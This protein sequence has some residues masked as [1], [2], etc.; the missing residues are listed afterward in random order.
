[1]PNLKRL[2]KNMSRR[3]EP[4]RAFVRALKADL[5]GKK[6]RNALFFAF[7]TAGAL[8]VI[9]LALGSASCVY[10]YR[11]PN[12]LPDHP[13][14]AV[15][16]AV[17]SAELSLVYMNPERAAEVA[18]KHFEK[19]VEEIGAMAD[20]GKQV[21]NEDVERVTRAAEAA[22]ESASSPSEAERLDE[23][24]RAA[25]LSGAG[26]LQRAAEASEYLKPAIRNGVKELGRMVR[27]MPVQRRETYQNI[28]LRYEAEVFGMK[29]K[30]EQGNV[31]VEDEDVDKII[32]RV[33]PNQ[34]I[35]AIVMENVE[36]AEKGTEDVSPPAVN[37]PPAFPFSTRPQIRATS[38]V[39]VFQP[40]IVQEIMPVR[41]IQNRET[42]QN[43]ATGTL[44]AFGGGFQSPDRDAMRRYLQGYFMRLREQ[45]R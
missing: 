27:R 3:A 25:E 43:N 20:G 6:P 4:D 38:S 13:L 16:R 32:E 14:Y 44:G 19:R 9:A 45:Q 37:V 2:L 11:S 10:A 7:R 1:M 5:V 35:E 12:V 15:R 29:W 23:R 30:M 28:E 22:I 33:V 36:K 40:P 17:E 26:A 18:V 8:L 34:D 21:K 42:E 24:I 39:P 41:Q 31:V